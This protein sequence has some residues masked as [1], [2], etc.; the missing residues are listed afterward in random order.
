MFLT[1]STVAMVTYY[2]IKIAHIF[3]HRLLETVYSHF[4][5]GC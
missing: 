1:G 4:N 3:L 5:F 2:S